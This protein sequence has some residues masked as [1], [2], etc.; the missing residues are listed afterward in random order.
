VVRWRT[1]LSIL[2]EIRADSQLP[3]PPC[4]SVFGADFA[5]ALN[6]KLKQGDSGEIYLAKVINL[7]ESIARTHVL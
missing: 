4:H 7:V 6:F 1:F 3:Q 2:S 5:D